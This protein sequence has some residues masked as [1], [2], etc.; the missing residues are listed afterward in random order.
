[1]SQTER[2]TIT[3]DNTKFYL[4]TMPQVALAR[5]QDLSTIADEIA[6]LQKS[7]D[8]AEIAK[9]AVIAEIA[10]LKGSFEAAE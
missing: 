8:I 3:I 7:I 6:S 10:K 5:L 4:D 2:K 9:G 1:M